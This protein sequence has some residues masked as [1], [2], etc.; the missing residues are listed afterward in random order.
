M[1]IQVV[2]RPT[3]AL[4]AS[5]PS[6]GVHSGGRDLTQPP[7]ST[8][9]RWR[10]AAG[11][12]GALRTQGPRLPVPTGLRVFG[13]PAQGDAGLVHHPRAAAA[14]GAAGLRAPQLHGAPGRIAAGRLDHLLPGAE[15]TAPPRGSPPLP[16]S[17]L[18]GRGPA[19]RHHGRL[20]PAHPAPSGQGPARPARKLRR[21][22]TGRDRYSRFP[23][24][25][26]LFSAYPIT[27]A[28]LG[29]GVVVG[30]GPQ[31]EAAPRP[32]AHEASSLPA[33][34]CG[35]RRP[36]DG[37]SEELAVAERLLLLQM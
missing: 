15:V 20:R 5:W 34:A 16:A 10:L 13:S 25:R 23:K 28:P 6:G 30:P 26:P 7:A 35:V 36:W 27:T 8:S 37:G 31:V 1:S 2:V 32:P 24:S 29:R 18:P 3:S 4:W 33:C 21:L 9:V 22:G 12:A 19:T 14:A 17:S 11:G